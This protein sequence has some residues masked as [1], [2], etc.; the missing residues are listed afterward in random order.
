[1]ICQLAIS[2]IKVL[3][4]VSVQNLLFLVALYETNGNLIKSGSCIAISRGTLVTPKST[5]F[6]QI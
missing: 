1:M 3:A 4:N 6:T 5:N 2:W